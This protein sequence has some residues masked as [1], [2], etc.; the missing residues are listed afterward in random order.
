VTN[1]NSPETG[2]D[3]AFEKATFG[4]IAWR[5]VPLL[6][7]GYFVA[8]LD[9]VNVGFAKLQMASDLSLSDEVYGFGAGIFFIGYFFF[10]MPS[11][12]ILAKVGA[13]RWIARIMISW[14]ILSSAFMFTGHLHWGQVS[15]AFGCT[16]AEFSFYVMRFLLGLAEAGF[17]PG[18]I[19][20]LTFWFPADRRAHVI[21]LF[22]TAIPVSNVIG[23]PLSGAILEYLDGMQGMRGWQWL[24]LIEGIPS[25]LVGFLLL[26]I[27]PDGPAKA[28]WLTDDERAV[29]TRRLHADEH[30]KAGRG[31][32]H[33][34]SEMFLDVRVWAFALSFFCGNVGFYALSF[35]MP[36]IIQ[37]VGIDPQDYLRVGLLATIPYGAA[38][39][40]MVL[41]ARHSDRT[42][43]RRWHA[44]ISMLVSAS[45]QLLLAFLGHNP[46]I[47]IVGLTL[48][49]I[50]MLS[51]LAVSWSVPTSFLSGVAAAGGIAWI[52]SLA[53][54]GGY[55]G[56]DLI[57]RI[58]E[59]NGG[60]AQAAFLVL[61]GA[62]LLGAFLSWLI[63][64][65]GAN[66]TKGARRAS[67]QIEP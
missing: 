47:S 49:A 32:R 15:A 44:T 19:L 41:W 28:K 20:Y 46:I 12:I 61:A 16:D 65:I 9:R 40:A 26:A 24:F 36:T 63:P 21:A 43:E 55:F 51:W 4:K 35:W 30:V 52:N 7:I 62:A 66:G 54:L 57:G 10:E 64:T 17:Y 29:V 67:P 48:V 38:G 58:R 6:F 13:R 42:G 14:G 1:A 18:V 37:E 22:M 53:N 34:V 2:A 31:Q 33:K 27:L 23:S 11:N 60:E 45:G 56:P 8:Y 5:L 59:A 50:G 3:A 39:V 25:V